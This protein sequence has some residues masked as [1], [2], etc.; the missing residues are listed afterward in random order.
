MET[1]DGREYW[2]MSSVTHTKETTQSHRQSHEKSLVFG[3]QIIKLISI[4]ESL[5]FFNNLEVTA[6]QVA[7]WTN[8][9]YW[10]NNITINS[11]VWYV[12]LNG[13]VVL[14]MLTYTFSVY[15]L[16]T[17]NAAP[18]RI[19]SRYC[20]WSSSVSKPPGEKICLD[21]RDF[22]FLQDLQEM[23]WIQEIIP[24]YIWWVRSKASGTH[25]QC[26]VDWCILWL[27]LCQWQG[28]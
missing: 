11:I 20:C 17:F 18:A 26:T 1:I 15:S 7:N 13:Y 25:W 22:D 14:V 2:C 28:Y 21:H 4:P 23:E 19:N 8:P 24:W 3:V 12:F 10:I 27:G 6:P 16:N 9:S 5:K